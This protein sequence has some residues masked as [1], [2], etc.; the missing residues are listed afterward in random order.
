MP[1]APGSGTISPTARP[2]VS[3]E[4]RYL[5]RKALKPTCACPTFTVR[6]NS[7]SSSCARSSS[8]STRKPPLSLT[9]FPIAASTIGTASR[10]L[11]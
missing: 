1:R 10:T 6:R 11:R 4:S 3:S 5:S 2:F 7:P 8:H 9:S